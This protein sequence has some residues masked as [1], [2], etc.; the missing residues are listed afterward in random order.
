MTRPELTVFN[1]K[2]SLKV[3]HVFTMYLHM[4]YVKN[5]YVYLLH[6]F[7]THPSQL[8]LLVLAQE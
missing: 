8:S 4:H 1:K 7:L 6:I 2:H 5:A 3:Y